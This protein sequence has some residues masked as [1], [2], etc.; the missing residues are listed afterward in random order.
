[1]STDYKTTLMQNEIDRLRH[2]IA[3]MQ[4]EAEL[5]KADL[6]RVDYRADLSSDA[7]PPAIVG[8]VKARLAMI[9]ALA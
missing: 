2:A 8:C 5:A 6:D 9:K 3:L 1:M 7:C 4:R